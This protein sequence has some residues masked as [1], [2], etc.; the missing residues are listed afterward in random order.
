MLIRA[1]LYTAEKHKGQ[2][3]I[4]G[5]P[6]ITHPMA[7]ARILEEK[8]F[9]T[10][11]IIAGLFHDLKED[12]DATDE[13]IIFYGNEEVLATVNLL[14]KRKGYVMQDYITELAQ[15]VGAKMVKLADRLHNLLSATVA[16]E[17]FRKRYIQET[18]EYYVA[19]AKGTV[20]EKDINDALN[21]LKAVA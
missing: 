1:V 19:L 17:S 18:E 20:F 7:V 6:Y 16:S 11:Y 13:E 9:T 14:T 15:D 3:R 5:K 12:T 10:P 2:T 21:Q 8:G 4:G